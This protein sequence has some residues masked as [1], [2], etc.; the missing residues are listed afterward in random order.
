MQLKIEQLDRQEPLLPVYLL[1]GDEPFQQLTAQD[2][3]RRQARAQGFD[4]RQVFDFSDGKP[5]W[6]SLLQ[7]S[8]SMGLFAS[9]QLLE[10]RLGEKR[11]DKEGSGT[12]ADILQRNDGSVLLI[13]SCS[14]LDKRRDIP[15]TWVKA[16]DQ[17]G[18]IVNIWP[19]EHNRLP[20]WAHQQLKK[21]GLDAEPD[22]LQLLAERSE[23]NLLALSQEI[24][25]L[26]LLHPGAK[27]T[28]EHIRDSVADSSHFSLF[29]LTA[30]T[31]TGDARRALNIL[32]HLRE[33]G[34]AESLL[35]WNLSREL[36]AMEAVSCGQPAGIFL[37]RP[38]MQQLEQQAKRL[39]TTRLQELLQL[40]FKT[41]AQTKGQAPGNAW[42]SLAALVLAMAG[43]PLPT[44]FTRF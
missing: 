36:R 24:E 34:E 10:L 29:D 5:D 14:R 2:A 42:D 21:V 41:D 19:V 35:L 28:L 38:R 33:E 26:S 44:A 4:E 8:Q 32:D 30:A 27:L 15:S 23:G 17:Q 12:L 20:G 37:P 3:L 11:P 6:S 16:V 18:A 13:I 39:G 7:A 31:S 25:K 9:R 40:A 43:H 1:A 22:A